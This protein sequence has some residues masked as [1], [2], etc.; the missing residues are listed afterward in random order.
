MGDDA[1]DERREL[2][3]LRRR[4]YG[5]DAD[6]DGDPAAM[7]RLSELENRDR[8]SS[9]EHAPDS[10]SHSDSES[11]SESTDAVTPVTSGHRRNPWPAAAASV[12]ALAIIAIAWTLGAASPP[13]NAGPEPVP[14]SPIA[15]VEDQVWSATEY[16]YE[17]QRPTLRERALGSGGAGGSTRLAQVELDSLQPKGTLLERA[18]WV[19][20]NRDGATC[21]VL[22]GDDGP[23][24]TCAEPS[25]VDGLGLSVLAPSI[26]ADD[27]SDVADPA[28]EVRFTLHRDGTVTAEPVS[29]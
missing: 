22:G 24:I 13:E 14:S 4:A 18:V 7:T 25:W 28:A 1:D 21:L 5:P 11:E 12:A 29:R 23:I 3:T 26:G 2:A 19:G 16:G 17:Q 9:T 27:R 6:I 20:E 15:P 10:D 8:V